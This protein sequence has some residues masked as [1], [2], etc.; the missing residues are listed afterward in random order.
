MFLFKYLLFDYKFFFYFRF[1]CD[2]CV[3][4]C[5]SYFVGVYYCCVYM[6]EEV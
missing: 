4:C 5:Y 1:G 2:N 6:F 3:S